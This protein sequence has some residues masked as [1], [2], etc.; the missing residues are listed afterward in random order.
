V[1]VLRTNAN[2]SALEAMLVYKQ[3]WTGELRKSNLI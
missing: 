1:F 2:L 3:L